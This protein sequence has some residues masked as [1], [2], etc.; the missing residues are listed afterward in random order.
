MASTFEI[1]GRRQCTRCLWWVHP[2]VLTCQPCGAADPIYSMLHKFKPVIN[3]PKP[4]KMWAIQG[5][6]GD[7][8]RFVYVG[9]HVTRRSMIAEHIRDTGKTWPQCLMS[10]DRAVRVLVT[11]L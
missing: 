10:G 4:T 2:S 8:K 7:D 5:T 3:K 6:W 1:K 9:T 11:V